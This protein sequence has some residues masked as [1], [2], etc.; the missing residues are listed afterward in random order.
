MPRRNLQVK[1]NVLVRP[2]LVGIEAEQEEYSIDARSASGSSTK[3]VSRTPKQKQ[4]H[5]PP[6]PG[7]EKPAFANVAAPAE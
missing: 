5:P 4:E 7:E 2:P 6:Q 1:L 3:Y